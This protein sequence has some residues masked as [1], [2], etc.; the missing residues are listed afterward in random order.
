MF[1]FHTC[2]VFSHQDACSSGPH[3]VHSGSGLYC[4]WTKFYL[5]IYVALR[6]YLVLFKNCQ[7][8]LDY[9]K[10]APSCW[11][12]SNSDL[13]GFWECESRWSAEWINKHYV[14]LFYGNKACFSVDD[15]EATVNLTSTHHVCVWLWRCPVLSCCSSHLNSW[16]QFTSMP[17]TSSQEVNINLIFTV[18]YKESRLVLS[19]SRKMTTCSLFLV[20]NYAVTWLR[21][22]Q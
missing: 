16:M 22:I 13:W 14:I 1:I 6:R 4:I 9:S 2:F 21:V 20:F 3:T 7:D 10:T 18:Y 17:C 12:N 5:F 19:S 15:R 8:V 11:S